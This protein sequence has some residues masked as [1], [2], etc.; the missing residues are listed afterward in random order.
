MQLFTTFPLPLVSG[1]QN[2]SS[3]GNEPSVESGAWNLKTT[4]SM[5]KP[6][7][8]DFFFFLPA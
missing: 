1:R 8:V 6:L 7:D 2:V 3:L 4:L 5:L